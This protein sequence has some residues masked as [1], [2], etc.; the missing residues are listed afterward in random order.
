MWQHWLFATKQHNNDNALTQL[1]LDGSAIAVT[2]GSYYES[3]NYGTSAWCITT[4]DYEIMTEGTS[5][6]PGTGPIHSSFC[7]EMV[8][9]LA[10]LTCIEKLN[11]PLDAPNANLHIVC[12]NEKALEVVDEWTMSKMTPNHNNANIVSNVLS[13]RDSLGI[14]ITTEHVYGHQDH[15]KPIHLLPPQVQ[16]NIQMDKKARA[17]ALQM[18]NSTKPIFPQSNHYASFSPCS[19]N[20]K[21]ILQMPLILSTTT[22]PMINY[23]N[24]G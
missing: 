5:I 2:D 15:S 11:I 6:V 3:D 17:Y 22:Q 18:I 21:P 24:I 13:V 9:I 23:N 8:G 7:S 16:M 1:I 12:D 4:K 19:W 10:I 14:Q 20:N